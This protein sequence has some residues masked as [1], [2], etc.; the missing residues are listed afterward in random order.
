MGRI[1]RVLLGSKC[2]LPVMLVETSVKDL[3]KE[4]AGAYMYTCK[5][6]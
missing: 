4:A 5:Y 2:L 3:E 6:I 1:P